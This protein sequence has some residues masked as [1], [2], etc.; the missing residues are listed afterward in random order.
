MVTRPAEARDVSGSSHSLRHGLE[1][2]A[3]GARTLAAAVSSTVLAPAKWL[4]AEAQV[5]IAASSAASVPDISTERA[6]STSTS[7]G[8]P[9][10]VGMAPAPASSTELAGGGVETPPFA[11]DPLAV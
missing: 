4:Q 10:A 7:A 5:V 8:L 9:H 3:E 1:S 6:R 11:Q 2:I